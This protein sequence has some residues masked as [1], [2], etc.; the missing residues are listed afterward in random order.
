MPRKKQTEEVAQQGAA[1]T[2]T[3]VA[4]NNNGDATAQG[5]ELPEHLVRRRTEIGR[6]VS[7]KMEKTV[8]VLVDRAKTHPLYKKVMRRS[9]KFMAHDEL[10]AKTGDRVRIIESRPMS[11]HKRWRVIEIIQSAD[12][13]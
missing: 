3:A 7:D 8:V 11:A 2:E 10:G 1:T 6:V 12:R 13:V 4:A 9:V 5:G